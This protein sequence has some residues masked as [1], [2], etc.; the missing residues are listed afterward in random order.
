M[1][2]C[3][4]Y[5]RADDYPLG[6]PQTAADDYGEWA[7]EIWGSRDYG[8]FEV[9]SR[10]EDAEFLEWAARARRLYLSPLEARRNARWASQLDI[11][12]ALSSVRVPTLVM[13]SAGD[14]LV[15]LTAGRYL[16][17]NL[18]NA[19]FVETTRPDYFVFSLPG[20]SDVL[21]HIEE[22]VTGEPPLPDPDRSFATILFT[23]IVSSTQAVAEMGDERWTQ[24]LDQHDR[25]VDRELVHHR[26]HK[27]VGTG[28]GVL[29][30]FDGPARAVRCARAI[31][32]AVRTLGIEVRAG[33]HAGEVEV[34]GNDI[35]GIA[36]HIGQ[37]VSTLAAPGEVLVS[38]TIPDLVA[39]SGLAFSD[40]GGHQ[41]KGVPGTW[42]VFAVTS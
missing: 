31:V 33:L 19:R 17:D 20:S 12:A 27:V 6:A 36:V 34:R 7:G 8:A 13:N 35:G 32:E 23:D 2:S 29:A 16:A 25:I 21:D 3:A 30:T 38:R 11:R 39:G 14:P 41:L 15:P 9:P 42:Q 4:R 18:P 5:V 40:R 28:D 22:F 37:R 24:L 10:A 1:S 26:G